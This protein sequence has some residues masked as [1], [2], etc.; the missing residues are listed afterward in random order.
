MKRHFRQTKF[1]YIYFHSEVCFFAKNTIIIFSPP[2]SSHS[3]IAVM[4]AV[5]HQIASAVPKPRAVYN[6]VTLW[7]TPRLTVSINYKTVLVFWNICSPFLRKDK[8]LKQKFNFLVIKRS[9]GTN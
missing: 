7:E 4:V 3:I 6:S 2:E 1:L 8:K 9:S 5:R